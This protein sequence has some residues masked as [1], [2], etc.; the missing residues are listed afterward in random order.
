MGGNVCEWNESLIIFDQIPDTFRG[1]GGGAYHHQFAQELYSGLRNYLQPA[2]DLDG[3]G[4]RI[5]TVPE[6]STLAL[7]VLL[8]S[9]PA[10]RSAASDN[11]FHSHRHRSQLPWLA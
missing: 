10:D 5:A 2:T 1:T 4:F 6:P 11:H 3:F 9:W 7:A 8:R